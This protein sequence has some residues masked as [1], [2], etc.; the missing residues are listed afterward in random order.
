M[1]TRQL[2]KAELEVMQILW[3]KEA[4]FVNEILDEMPEPRPAYNTVS[5]VVRVLE[6]KGVVGHR[7]FGKSHQYYPLIGK[8]EYTR[9][10]MRGVMNNFFDNSFAQMF[11]FFC[12]K[13]NLSVRETEKIIDLA[14]EAIA[15]KKN[16]K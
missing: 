5:T 13:E 2:T 6:K 16:P 3:Q 12:E 7:S 10:F 8:E 4:A 14:K 11:S 1:E 9:T 15:R